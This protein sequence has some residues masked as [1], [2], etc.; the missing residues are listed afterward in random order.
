MQNAVFLSTHYGADVACVSLFLMRRLDHL[1]LIM[2]FPIRALVFARGCAHLPVS[3]G[4]AGKI[5]HPGCIGYAAAFAA[6]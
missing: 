1:L 4:L 2:T 5:R 6:E 3:F